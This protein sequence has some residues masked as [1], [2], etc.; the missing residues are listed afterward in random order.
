MNTSEASNHK[1][2][3]GDGGVEPPRT[4]R[5]AMASGREVHGCE[6]RSRAN[7]PRGSFSR[8]VLADRPSRGALE[9][10]WTCLADDFEPMADWW[11]SRTNAHTHQ[12]RNTGNSNHEPLF[13]QS[14][15]Q[16]IN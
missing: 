9:P 6:V 1:E 11:R 12:R 15:N 4:G 10:L 14:I 13:N 16:S 7:I 5:V 8:S 2:Q 3:C